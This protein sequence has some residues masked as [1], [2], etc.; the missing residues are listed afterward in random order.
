MLR[1]C[2]MGEWVMVDCKV[3]DSFSFCEQRRLLLDAGIRIFGL[4]SLG[5]LRRIKL[6]SGL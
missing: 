1:A 2:G 6:P 4:Y 3:Q 5:Q